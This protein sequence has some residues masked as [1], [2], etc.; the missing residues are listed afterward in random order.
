MACVQHIDA[1][2]GAAEQTG[3]GAI[4]LGVGLAGDLGLV[5]RRADG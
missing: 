5:S 1:D 2:Q 4:A 3:V